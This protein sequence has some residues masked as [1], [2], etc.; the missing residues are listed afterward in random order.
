M[1]KFYYEI[2]RLKS[3]RNLNFS[4]IVVR[5]YIQTALTLSCMNYDILTQDFF[6]FV[7][8]LLLGHEK[9]DLI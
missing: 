7:F 4:C 6:S 9:Q 3:F 1:S 2:L 5:L 8:L